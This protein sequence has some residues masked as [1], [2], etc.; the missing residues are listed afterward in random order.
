VEEQYVNLDTLFLVVDAILFS[1]LVHIKDTCP[2]K[3]N[4]SYEQIY[5]DMR[6][7]VDLCH[8]D[9]V[10]KDAVAA[11]P[12]DYIKYD[13][14]LVPML[15]R[16]KDGGKKVFLLTNSLWDYT[17]T[18]MEYLVHG[19]G[20][21][22]TL[23]WTDL[24]DAVVVGACK[25]N[26][27]FESN[28]SMFRVQTA[29][30]WLKN[31]DAHGEG[32]RVLEHG[33]VFQGG[34]WMHLNNMLAIPSGDRVLYVGDHMYSDILSSKRTLGWRTCLIIP[35]L[36][37]ELQV[38]S[39]ERH[40][41]QSI[42]ELR[43]LQYDLDEWVDILKLRMSSKW[44]PEDE[45]RLQAALR[46]QAQVKEELGKLSKSY[47]EKFHRTWGQLF[48]AGYQD[49]RFAHQVAT[50]A[51]L[52]TSRASNLGKISPERHFRPVQD[53]LPHEQMLLET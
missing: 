31:I 52:Y 15:K 38:S 45:Q 25:P 48:K 43:A 11:N 47:H 39:A 3:I 24:F 8:R 2:S 46:K 19:R 18:V 20:E 30:G 40:S 9:G 51:C 33:K 34:N 53:L 49:S 17:H 41:R 27:L 16:F 29:T 13:E 1:H 10:I 21:Y 37:A 44:S 22:S 5:K 14:K 4:R 6:H 26:Y 7:A 36:D 32:K 28:R 42:M 12:S 50:Y 23:N 35:E